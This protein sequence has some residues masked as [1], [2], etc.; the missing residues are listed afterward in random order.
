MDFAKMNDP[1][2]DYFSSFN[3]I[4]SP[5]SEADELF[6]PG[7]GNTYQEVYAGEQFECSDPINLA[8]HEYGEL[9]TGSPIIHHY[10]RSHGSD[11]VGLASLRDI[12]LA[13]PHG[14]L[15]T[16]DLV[17]VADSY[18]IKKMAAIPYRE[19]RDLAQSLLADPTGYN[20]IEEPAV[21]MIGP[22][23]WN[24]HHWLLE[25]LPRLW[26]LGEYPQ[27]ADCPI[28]VPGDLSAFQKGSLRALGIAENRLRFFDGSVWHFDRLY[29]PSF[30]APGGHSTR[31][32]NWLRDRLFGAF[33]VT[34][35]EKGGKSLYLTRRG[36]ASKRVLNE[37]D[38]ESRLAEFGF[39]T[40]DPGKLTLRE[41]V[42]LFNQASF[43]VAPHG[44][45]LTNLVFMPSSASVI[46]L[47]PAS[48]VNRA[49]WYLANV[50]CQKYGFLIGAP[51][52]ERQDYNIDPGDLEELFNLLASA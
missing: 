38:I 20:R 1:Y 3:E 52:S 36:A 5:V 7:Q 13:T 37:M 28:I 45:S 44:A 43:I 4:C 29:V 2:Q 42:Q 41:Q 9:F 51:E 48:F 8:G 25:D 18:H 39:E 19:V 31:Q 10:S 14:F 33:D 16:D 11:P 24:Y 32:F 21:L 35:A 47:L 12:I 34:L 6:A 22:W 15:F 49:N 27:L 50:R 23:S 17:P 26:V 46:E 40:I 30:L